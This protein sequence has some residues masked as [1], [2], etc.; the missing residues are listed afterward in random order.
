M[1]AGGWQ[2]GRLPNWQCLNGQVGRSGCH[3]HSLLAL[4][5]K[6]EILIPEDANQRC[7]LMT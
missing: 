6:I 4:G 5:Q 1:K 7:E 3:H 2:R